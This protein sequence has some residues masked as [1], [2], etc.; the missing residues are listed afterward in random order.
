MAEN[1]DTV[2]YKHFMNTHVDATSNVKTSETLYS[3]LTPHAFYDPSLPCKTTNVMR[4]EKIGMHV[5]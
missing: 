2:I 3:C 5:V 1:R 4:M